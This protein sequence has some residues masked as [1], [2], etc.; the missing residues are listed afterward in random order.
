MRVNLMNLFQLSDA[1]MS[2]LRRA[3]IEYGMRP[4]P[5]ALDDLARA[6]RLRAGPE[7][8]SRRSAMMPQSRDRV[9]PGSHFE[10]A[11]RSHEARMQRLRKNNDGNK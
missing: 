1:S 2:M 8:L 11:L 4:T 10:E 7:W 5:A 6:A 3:A 9:K